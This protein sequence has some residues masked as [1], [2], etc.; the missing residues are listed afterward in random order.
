MKERREKKTNSSRAFG[1]TNA[2]VPLVRLQVTETLSL[3]S[4]KQSQSNAS[5]LLLS[6]KWDWE[7]G[8]HDAGMAQHKN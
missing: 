7:F 5:D 2:K 6:V 1:I 3:T 4:V 8:T